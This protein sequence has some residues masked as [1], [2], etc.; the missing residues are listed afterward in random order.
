MLWNPLRHVSLA[1]LI[2]LHALL[3]KLFGTTFYQFSCSLTSFSCFYEVT[4][5]LKNYDSKNVSSAG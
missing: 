5:V 3:I 4:N 2:L 1:K